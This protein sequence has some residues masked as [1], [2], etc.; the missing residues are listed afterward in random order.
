MEML[1]GLQK[2]AGLEEGDI[3]AAGCSTSEIAGERIG[4]HSSQEIA[5]SLMKE[6]LL[7][8]VKQ[9]GLYLA[10][11]CC[12]HLNRALVVE[13]ECARAFDFTVVSVVPYLKAGGALATEA[14][15]SFAKPVVVE[16]INA[17]A[18]AGIDI[19]DTFIGMHLRRVA[20]PV[21]LAQNSLGGA[22]VTFARTRPPFIGGERARYS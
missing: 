17:K 11:Q 12:E 16:A 20:V 21:R 22:H 4:T 6:A 14:M 19:G 13:A 15:A 10:V 1:E 18:R 9:R 5:E 2:A 8:F 3:L 7:P